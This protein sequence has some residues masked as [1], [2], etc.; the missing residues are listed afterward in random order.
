MITFLTWNLRCFSK[1]TCCS[2]KKT[3][4]ST[5]EERSCCSRSRS[6]YKQIRRE[7]NTFNEM[8]QMR[9]QFDGPLSRSQNMV[10]YLCD[11][12][13][14]KTEVQQHLPSWEGFYT[15]TSPADIDNRVVGYLPSIGQSPTKMET[16][17]NLS[18]SAKKLSNRG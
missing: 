18:C 12:F 7:L 2:E 1:L 13:V 10:F 6:S 15:L 14:T 11:Y 3:V 8:D 5:I 9:S 17:S 4:L 16:A